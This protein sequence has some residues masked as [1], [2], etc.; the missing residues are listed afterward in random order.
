MT[1][2]CCRVDLI[3]YDPQECCLLEYYLERQSGYRRKYTTALN[4][5]SPR[6]HPPVPALVVKN[7]R[8]NFSLRPSR[9]SFIGISPSITC[10]YNIRWDARV[11]RQAQV[12]DVVAFHGASGEWV[13]GWASGLWFGRHL[14]TWSAQD[15]HT[16]DGHTGRPTDRPTDPSRAHLAPLQRAVIGLPLTPPACQRQESF[17]PSGYLVVGWGDDGCLILAATWRGRTDAVTVPWSIRP[18]VWVWRLSTRNEAYRGL[19][20]AA[21]LGNF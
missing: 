4:H 8:L 6:R 13:D 7:T 9:E 1:S 3:R 10:G 17:H 21:T 5:S 20:A 18:S 12:S 19:L 16:T 15:T 11:F 2:R 14:S